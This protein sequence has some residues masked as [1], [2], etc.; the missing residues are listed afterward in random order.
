MG[1]NDEPR[2]DRENKPEDPGESNNWL[3]KLASE[4][5]SIWD[6]PDSVGDAVADDLLL[7]PAGDEIPDW[8][9][10]DLEKD[11]SV[12]EDVP[13]W[14]VS[15][16]EANGTSQIGDDALDSSDPPF[17]SEAG[18]VE[19]PA[20]KD[21]TVLSQTEQ[22]LIEEDSEEVDDDVSGEDEFKW[23]E[24]T[25]AGE[26]AAIEEPP[27]INEEEDESP[28][29][30][31]SDEPEAD[32]LTFT[33]VLEA[34]SE[35]ELNAE[36]AQEYAGFPD[37]TEM[38]D[39]HP[40]AVSGDEALDGGEAFPD[41][42]PEDPDEAMV[43]LERLAA[44]QGA[45]ME[46]LPSMREETAAT[47]ESEKDPIADAAVEED[48]TPSI[49]SQAQDSM[50]GDVAEEVAAEIVEPSSTPDIEDTLVYGM[51]GFTAEDVL[52]EIGQKPVIE[53]DLVPP[54]IP[55]DP[56][57][58]IIWIEELSARQSAPIAK[59]SS[60]E[61][62]KI[63]DGDGPQ[64]EGE[65][66][67]VTEGVVPAVGEFELTGELDEALNWLEEMVD[68]DEGDPAEPVEIVEEQITP[69]VPRDVSIAEEEI[70]ALEVESVEQELE[71]PEKAFEVEDME[72]T[73]E[74][75]E[76]FAWLD[77]LAESGSE[78][79]DDLV[80]PESDDLVMLESE[81][82]VSPDSDDLV[83][84]KLDKEV[85]EM[86]TL[87]SQ[88]PVF[89]SLEDPLPIQEN[90][91]DIDKEMAWLDTLGAVR[92]EEWLVGEEEIPV[93][94]SESMP[95][96]QETVEED[97]IVHES[98]VSEGELVEDEVR[99]E[100]EDDTAPEEILRDSEKAQLGEARSALDAGLVQQ[101]LEQYESL[102]DDDS[103]IPFVISDL[104]ASLGRDGDQ[105]LVQRTLGDAYVRNGQLKKALDLYRQALDLL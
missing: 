101:A 21:K 3:D 66:D 41:E 44:K 92:A 45:P 63:A 33:G 40:E 2:D 104:E 55:E 99:T 88:E 13:E 1:E 38:P 26:G 53:P 47:F 49:E 18:D 84:P 100:I 39:D 54:E 89:E 82:L 23:L 62:E 7:D 24:N 103:S 69:H 96:S 76:A 20:D 17:D 65:H 48:S 79:P 25:A 77:H 56:D 4:A 43:W 52:D 9:K 30:T 14:L 64:L 35:V 80:A 78:L 28:Q 27:P 22:V 91:D 83:I 50:V 93:Q 98:I 42:V 70:P 86:P 94:E 90:D 5:G 11:P 67:V 97:P 10:A 75:A 51:S 16:I 32:S 46:E 81:D 34:M 58:A 85:I 60:A 74:T 37:G 71:A 102:L 61:S 19:A 95:P 12:E 31:H 68:L 72:A 36:E 87:E 59:V 73:D 29:P 15:E 6:E 8:L 57:E 105:L